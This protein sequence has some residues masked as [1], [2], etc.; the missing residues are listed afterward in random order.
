MHARFVGARGD[1]VLA[2]VGARR[3]RDMR[4]RARQLCAAVG[5]RARGFS[6]PA[7]NVPCEPAR[8]RRRRRTVAA[9][10][11]GTSLL[12]GSPSARAPQR[13]AP[14]WRPNCRARRGCRAHQYARRRVHVSLPSRSRALAETRAP[15]I[16]TASLPARLP[17]P[18]ARSAIPKSR[19]HPWSLSKQRAA[20]LRISKSTASA[21][22]RHGRRDRRQR[23]VA[24]D[25]S[26]PVLEAPRSA[27]AAAP[28]RRRLG[29]PSWP[30][31]APSRERGRGR[32][33]GRARRASMPMHS[34]KAAARRWGTRD[35]RTRDARRR[36]PLLRAATAAGGHP[37]G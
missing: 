34:K 37:C 24:S 1:D 8:C 20:E 33:R 11:R 16:P 3:A 2:V 36:I 14:C 5:R 18:R 21:R 10:G 6:S 26:T 23:G 13:L 4:A 12:G 22:V 30:P 7:L 31:S 32:R 25:I 9:G 29:L 15:A 35:E 27:A 28:R 17:G 19:A